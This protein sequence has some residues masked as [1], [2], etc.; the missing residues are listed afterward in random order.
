M[1]LFVWKT[2]PTMNF[3][4]PGAVLSLLVLSVVGLSGCGGADTP[5][6]GRVSG[7]VTMGG[8][9][10]VGVIVLFKPDDG[11]AATGTTDDQGHYEMEYTY[12]VRGAKVGPSTVMFEWP[13]GAKD[14]KPLDPKYTIKSELK[15]DVKAGSNTF[16]FDLE[17]DPSKKLKQAD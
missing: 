3:R 12:K 2:S 4:R 10:L 8:Q 13:L 1:P 9:P 16:D 14:P 6:L 5:P 7:K 15:R 11:R 17:G